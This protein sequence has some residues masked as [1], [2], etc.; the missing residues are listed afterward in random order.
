MGERCEEL[1]EEINKQTELMNDASYNQSII[2]DEYEK[3]EKRVN[4]LQE[5]LEFHIYKFD[6]NKF[7]GND[8]RVGI[9][10][11]IQKLEKSL[12]NAQEKHAT[13]ASALSNVTTYITDQKE[14][15]QQLLD[16][17]ENCNT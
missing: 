3:S 1:K 5:K 9:A 6:N 16:K 2:E 11:K 14:L 15:I 4:Q 7:N 17:L 12:A 10:Q 8:E 13:N